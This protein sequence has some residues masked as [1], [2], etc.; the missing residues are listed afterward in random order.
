L[1]LR[2]LDGKDNY[3][4]FQGDSAVISK[5]LFNGSRLTVFPTL[6][7]APLS[8]VLL[9]LVASLL[10]HHVATKLLDEN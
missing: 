5:L 10:L 9:P 4:T 1:A 3:L 8:A 6:A 7:S 2:S